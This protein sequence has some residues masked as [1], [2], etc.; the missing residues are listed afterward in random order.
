MWA[1]AKKSYDECKPERIC[2]QIASFY[3]KAQSD[4]Y[5][6]GIR[7]LIT[8]VAIFVHHSHF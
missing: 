1:Q 2:L 3:S 7:H 6:I 4:G 5:I 8:H